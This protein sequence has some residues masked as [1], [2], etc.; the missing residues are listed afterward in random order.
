MSLARWL[1]GACAQGG[2]EER[3]RLQ[4]GLQWWQGRPPIQTAQ[5]KWRE[6]QNICPVGRA[7]CPASPFLFR[8]RV[9]GPGKIPA[10]KAGDD[11]RI[12]CRPSC[13]PRPTPK[14]GGTQHGRECDAGGRHLMPR[15][16]RPTPR[17]RRPQPR[18]TPKNGGTQHGRDKG[19]GGREEETKW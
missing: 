11:G 5:P 13:R 16:R 7:N 19:A 6:A 2:T 8:P 10:E 4:S 18:P 14:I 3:Q 9:G 12:L 15:P 17:P 1:S